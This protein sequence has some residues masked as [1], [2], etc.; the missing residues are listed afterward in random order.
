VPTDADVPAVPCGPGLRIAPLLNVTEP[1]IVPVPPNVVPLPFT[2]TLPDPVPDPVVLLT[3]SVP[4]LTVVPPEYIFAPLSRNVLVPVLIRLTLC[5]PSCSLIIPLNVTRPEPVPVSVRIWALRGLVIGLV[6]LFEIVK[7]P[8]LSW[9]IELPVRVKELPAIVSVTDAVLLR[10]HVPTTNVVPI[11]SVEVYAVDPLPP[12]LKAAPE[13]GTPEGLQFA[14]VAQ[15][16][17]VG[18]VMVPG[19]GPI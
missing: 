2:V 12:K 14:G 18:A 13:A 11:L 3:N 10:S 4:A 9:L 6:K 19:L 17:V 7:A 8:V 1:L 5:P 15:D 16:P